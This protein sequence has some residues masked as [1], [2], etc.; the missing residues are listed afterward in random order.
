M[1]TLTDLLTERIPPQ[2]LACERALIGAVLCGMD[3][4]PP[5][6]PTE[7]YKEA[8]RKIWAACRT[9]DELDGR[10]TL[11]TVAAYLQQEGELAEVGGPAHLAQCMDEGCAVTPLTGLARVIRDQARKRDMIRIG[12]D[13]V[14]SGYE[15][16]SAMAES[17]LQARLAQLPGPIAQG[18]WDPVET[19]VKIQTRWG[20]DSL[21]TGW[22]P[23][24]KITGGLW[25]GELLI[26][27]ARTS[28]GKTSYSTAA[29]L[30]MAASGIAVDI[31][32]LEDPVEAIERRLVAN[33]TGIHGRRLRQGPLTERERRTADLAVARLATYPLTVTGID[34]HGQASEDGVLGLLAHARGQVVILDHLQRVLTRDQSRAYALERVLGKIHAHVQRTGQVAWVNCQLNRNVEARKDGQPTL[35]DLRDS[36]AIE[37][38]A[39]QVWLLAWPIK[40]DNKRDAKD[41]QVV[42]AKNADGATGVAEMRWQA[43][44]GRFWTAEEGPPID[45]ADNPPLWVT[46]D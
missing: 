19:W 4:L 6:L 5:L 11:P 44:T 21:E 40:W 17:E 34:R 46:D 28:H 7:F 38:L 32:T 31:I 30:R 12:T 15:P 1:A 20:E 23:L 43:A 2:D 14:A 29:A 27:A 35:A 42:V 16:G 26:I 3:T 13:M 8:H 9:V 24:D 25:P 22:G 37:I 45:L 41:F 39:R 18:I 36:G 33:L 10:C